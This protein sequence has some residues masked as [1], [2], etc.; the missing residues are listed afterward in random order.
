MMEI[1]AGLGSDVPFFL[2]GGTAL[3][4][5]RG[6]ELYDLPDIAEAPLLLVSPGVHVATGPAYAALDRGLTFT[7]S[8]SSINSFQA[9]VRALGDGRGAMAAG[10]FSANDFETVVF[11][12]YP[13]LKKIAARMR[14]LGVGNVRMT[15]S[16]STIFALF[17]SKEERARAGR[18]LDGDRVFR[19]MGIMEAGLVS[20]RSYRR[21]WRRQL[22]EHLDPSEV[23]WPPRSRYAR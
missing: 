9:F 3:G 23:L 17:A 16:G 12:Q 4:L 11:R 5:G 8:S 22:R 10:A 19:D 20:R 15:G 2:T 1:G 7:G 21:M 6:T 13:Q 14:R 18:M